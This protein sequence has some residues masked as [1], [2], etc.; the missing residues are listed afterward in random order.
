M[1]SAAHSAVRM[2]CKKCLAHRVLHSVTAC[3]CVWSVRTC[4]TSMVSHITSM[5]QQV[6][7]F[8]QLCSILQ[9]SQAVHSCRRTIIVLWCSSK[10]GSGSATELMWRHKGQEVTEVFKC[11]M[12]SPVAA[13]RDLQDQTHHACQQPHPTPRLGACAQPWCLTMRQTLL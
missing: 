9:R 4:M 11:S 2:L 13:C 3:T 12:G 5:Q 6:N 1:C 8:Q 10:K 7:F